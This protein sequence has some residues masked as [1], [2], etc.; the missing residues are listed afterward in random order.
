M[1]ENFSNTIVNY[2]DA[3]KE[4]MN[5]KF[6]IPK[7][8]VE[9]YMDDVCFMVDGDKVYIQA[10]RPRIVWVK[11]LGYEL[12]IDETKDIIKSL[13]NRPVDPKASYIGTYD[14]AKARI[15]LEIKFPKV[16]NKGKR[17]IKKMK[18]SATLLL[19]EGKDEDVEKVEDEEE[20]EKEETL[21]KKG[22]V[23][24]TKP[25]K[26]S[27]IIFTRRSRKKA[28]KGGDIIF[29]RPPPTFQD[30][31]KELKDGA[32]ITN[33]KSLKYETRID[34]KKKKIKDL[35]IDKMGQWK[36]SPDQLASHISN[37][38]MDKIK[39]RWEHA[40]QIVKDI[41]GKNSRKLLPNISDAEV[42]E[43]LKKNEGKLTLK[44]NT[45]LN[46]MK[47][48]EYDVK[49]ATNTWKNV[50]HLHKPS[51]FLVDVK[52]DD[53]D[54]DEKDEEDDEGTTHFVTVDYEEYK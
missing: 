4:K 21:K 23:I 10:V 7:K 29:N 33:F 49:N 5:N 30:R 35:V 19:T 24:I 53:D 11:P 50:Y 3:F 42:K 14:E 1:G 52:D 41:Y 39:P 34:E 15:R 47:D 44:F 36:Y 12:N 27:T 28:K 48:I 6:R 20:F 26:P 37:V 17:R 54:N 43:S 46:L 32:S 25:T 8:L 18:L 45:Y 9:D 2:F 16:V 51:D 22:K 38:L 40:M 31:L 13:V